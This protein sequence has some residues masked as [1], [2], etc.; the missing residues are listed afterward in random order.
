MIKIPDMAKRKV[1]VFGLG[2]T[3]VSAAE[4]LV[5]SGAQVFTFDESQT[6]RD[7]T[8]NTEYRAEHPKQWPWKDL[9]ALVLSPGVPLTHPKPHAMVKKAQSEGVEIIGDIELFA[10]S[11]NAI[12]ENQRPKVVAVTGSN[13]KSTTTALI[14]RILK[15]A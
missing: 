8:G 11:L 5:A 9:S 1:G 13:G 7:K 4:A 3:G 12:P 2:A 6:A 14:G 10:R 15:E